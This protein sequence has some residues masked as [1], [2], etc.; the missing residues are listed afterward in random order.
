MKS[1]LLLFTLVMALFA[2]PSFQQIQ[3]LVETQNYKQAKFAL[4][5]V[6]SNHPNSSKAYYTLAQAEAGLGNLPAAQE[7]LTHA[8]AINP[9]LDFVPPSQI[10]KLEQAIT[11]Q[12]HLVKPVES[13]YFYLWMFGFIIII[14][15]VVYY[16]IRKPK[17]APKPEQPS[18]K[19]SYTP[20][21][22]PTPPS[23]GSSSTPASTYV[24]PT[25]SHTEVHHHHHSDT[26]M[27]TAGTILTAGLTAAAVTS[28][29]DHSQ[30]APIV[31]PVYP[32]PTSSSWEDSKPSYTSTHSSDYEDSTS[33]SS[34]WSDSSSSS[35]SWSD[36]SSSSSSSW[37]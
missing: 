25:P 27:G 8:K 33:R 6:I 24:D 17:P 14:G 34:S 16:V 21:P 11:P 13:S 5:L 15:G 2:E 1:L 18:T 29:M 31:T 7:A 9:S 12:T 30:P 28:M 37:D 3:Q 10:A 32:E 19:Y 22:K 26:G 4:Q 23:S 20:T 36:S 35:S